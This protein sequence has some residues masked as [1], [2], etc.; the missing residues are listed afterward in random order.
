MRNKFAQKLYKYA[1]KDKNIFVVAADISPSGDLAKLQKKYPDRFLNIGVAEQSMIGLCAGLSIMGKKAYAYS[2]STFSLYRPF[3][4][5]R[6]DLCYQN[7]P[8]T[9]VGMG[10]GTIYSSLGNTHMTI[11][12]VS[13]ARSIPNMK[14]LAPCDPN[15]L[16]YAVAY[17]YNNKKNPIYLRIGKSGEKN[18]TDNKSEK[19]V[20]GKIRKIQRGQR[21]AILSYGPIIKYAFKVSN[22]LTQKLNIKPNI[23]SCH[24]LKPFDIKG[25]IKIFKN[26]DVLCI[27]EDHSIIGGLSSIVK[28]ALFEENKQKKICFFSLKDE[29]LN[30][31]SNQENLLEKHGITPTKIFNKIKKLL[32]D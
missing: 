3:E 11:E 29:F 30:E 13:I 8:V 4:M 32:N 24:T 19:W 22:Y 16:E 21:I 15:E 6:D 28:Q 25:L 20:F 2:I 23:Y 1:V 7:L 5:I 10:A 12:D 18:F 31:Y 27:I 14:I 9:V 17:S 26:N